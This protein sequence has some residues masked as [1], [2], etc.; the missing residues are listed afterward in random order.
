VANLS[1]EPL[2]GINVWNGHHLWLEG[3]A[4]GETLDAWSVVFSL[5]PS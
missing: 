2:N 3:F 1:A 4:T 5:S